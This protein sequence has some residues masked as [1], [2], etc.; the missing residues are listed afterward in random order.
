MAYLG[1]V[2]GLRMIKVI[3]AVAKGIIKQE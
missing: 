3:P 2:V 1:V